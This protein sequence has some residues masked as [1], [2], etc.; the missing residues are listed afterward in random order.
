MAGIGSFNVECRTIYITGVPLK[1]KQPSAADSWLAIEQQQLEANPLR[2]V[3]ALLYQKFS[4]WGE[5]E[6]I[7]ISRKA[8][9]DGCRAFIRFAHR[10]Y[11]EFAREAMTD[12]M[13]VFEDQRQ[14]MVVRWAVD[15][16]GNPMDIEN[17]AEKANFEVR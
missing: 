6:D 2:D 4:P 11:A 16:S 7:A 10:Y 3:T 13:D 12:Q 1:L 14:P 5:I 17:E 9:R 8:N 15:G